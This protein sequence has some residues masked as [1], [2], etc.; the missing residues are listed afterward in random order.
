MVHLNLNLNTP[1]LVILST[2]LL[3]VKLKQTIAKF[4]MLNFQLNL[5]YDWLKT[6]VGNTFIYIYIH[7]RK[8]NKEIY[9]SNIKTIYFKN[10]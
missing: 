8:F 10:W 6:C 7:L 9:L 5:I 1:L 2:H 4:C 3:K